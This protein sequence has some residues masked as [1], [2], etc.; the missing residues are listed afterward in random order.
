M[1]ARHAMCAACPTL[2]AVTRDLGAHACSP[3]RSGDRNGKG[4]NGPNHVPLYTVFVH[5][6][7]CPAVIQAV[8]LFGGEIQQL[9]SPFAATMY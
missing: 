7:S 4:V 2:D 6:E 8:F 1:D 3:D 9:S 5:S